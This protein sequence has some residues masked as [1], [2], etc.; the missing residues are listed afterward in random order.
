MHSENCFIT[1]TY[2]DDFLPFGGSLYRP[3]FQK[4]CKRLR[5]KV[6]PFRLFY[7]GEYGETTRRPHYHAILFGFRPNDPEL[8]SQGK[9]KLYESKL[10][11]ETW[12]LGHASFG[13]ATFETA[14]YV[15]RYVTK[16]ITGPAAEKH[17]QT[18][19]P[20]TGEIY[21]LVPEFNGMS[22]RP[23][24][25][26]PW[27]KKY[28]RGAYERD[29]VV[30]RSKAMK[31]PRA[32]DLQ[33]EVTDPLLFQSVKLA[34]QRKHSVLPDPNEYLSRRQHAGDKIARQRLQLRSKI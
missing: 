15:A 22:R 3:D 24:I 4:F 19:D 34:R 11:R 33:F 2:D 7:C 12:G 31:P 6:G 27:L 17:Y 13:E 23:G 28:G 10:L 8:F 25:G 9:H 26:L 18:V 20:E 21:D 32:Y 30:L 16:K 5:K 29:E 1:L 14:A